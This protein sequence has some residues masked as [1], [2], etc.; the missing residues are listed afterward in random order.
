MIIATVTITL[1]APWVRS[2]KGKRAQVKSLLTKISHKFN[3]SVAE[4]ATQ[5]ILQTITIGIAAVAANRAQA[6]SILD[7]IINFVEKTSEAQIASVERE[8][9]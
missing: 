5:D 6:D 9:R 3:V 7:N 1:D 2:L 4:V 8:L